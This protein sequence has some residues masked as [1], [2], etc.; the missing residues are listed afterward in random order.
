MKYRSKCGKKDGES[1][2][3]RRA[4]QLFV[5]PTNGGWAV[6]RGL[7]DSPSTVHP[8]QAAATKAAKDS[9]RKQGSGELRIQSRNGRL[10]ESFVFSR[11]DFKKISA[12]EGLA[13]S[14]EIERDFDEFDRRGQSDYQRRKK[15]VHKYSKRRA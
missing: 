7:A 2:Y 12:I 14:P 1:G 6:K 3:R 5:M 8:T 10:R 11:S 15:I 4:N 13:H 9:L